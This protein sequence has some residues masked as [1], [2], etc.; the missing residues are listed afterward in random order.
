MAE[1]GGSGSGVLIFSHEQDVDGLLSAAVLK[2]AHPDA[3]VVL[4]NYGFDNMVAIRDR[5]LAFIQQQDEKEDK[6]KER[7]LAP[8]GGSGRPPAAGEKRIIIADI[9][10]NEDSHEPV[11][12]ALY[13]SKQRGFANMW[14]DHHPWPQEMKDKFSQVCELVFPRDSGGEEEAQQAGGKGD[15]EDDGNAKATDGKMCATELCI[16]RFSLDSPYARTLGAIAHRTDFPDS[17]RFPIPP[18][19][20]LISYYLGKGELNQKLYSVILDSVVRG[21]LWNTEM[22]DDMIEA[23]RLID[24]SMAR[25]IEAMTIREFEF[26]PL[27]HPGAGSPQPPAREGE[28]RK[29]RVAIARADSFVSR[30]MLLG[31]MM[32]ADGGNSDGDSGQAAAAVDLAIAYTAEGRLSIRRND[33]QVSPEK[34]SQLDCGKIAAMFREG[35]G[36]LAAAGGFLKANVRE[37]GDG[38]AVIEIESTLQNYFEQLEG[39]QQQQPDLP[40]PPAEF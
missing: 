21:V 36:H 17:A 1:K 7:Q 40:S 37:K 30:S 35:G 34:A 14:I 24:E 5:V 29:V 3:Q 28:V 11:Y 18:L 38:A 13:A 16:A 22:Q 19:T 8:D 20:G 2:M 25:S 33:R 9:G 26:A 12:R 27:L 6:R 39:Q 4:T 15:A 32:D 31:K 23:S 10:V